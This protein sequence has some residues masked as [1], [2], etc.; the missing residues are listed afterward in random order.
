MQWLIVKLSNILSKGSVI[1]MYIKIV[2][3]AIATHNG[4]RYLA[5]QLD[6]ILSQTYSNLEIV[7][8]DDD[9]VDNTLNIIKNYQE[10]F[11]N[12][13][14]I[15]NIINL[16]VVKSFELAINNCN[17]EF[18]VLAD[19]D[20]VWF[21]N[22][23][24]V[25]YNNIGDC[26][27]IHSDAI[28][29]N[30]KLQIL[31]NSH[32]KFSKNIHCS[33]ISNYLLSNNVTGC[34]TMLKKSFWDS[35]R[36]IPDGFYTHDHYLAIMAST[37]QNGIKYYPYPL[38]YYRQHSNNIIGAKIIKYD[39]FIKQLQKVKNSIILLKD[40]PILYNYKKD[41]NSAVA[42]YNCI[43]NSKLPNIMV[44]YWIYKNIPFRKFLGFI[45]CTI[46][47]KSITKLIYEKFR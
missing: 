1:L 13:K 40:N 7:I 9:S 24:E 26:L 43:I 41:I 18:I 10:K 8:V 36:P 16:G 27:L 21:K 4:E 47:N 30:E 33:G 28:L 12:I 22:K 6:S 2:S 19:Q 11:S 14:L 35:I 3:V 39:L 17:G 15:K 25:L 38:V 23:V 37:K 29:V 34:C 5:E 44:F 31:S 45:A 46:P 32:M 42:Y 20:D